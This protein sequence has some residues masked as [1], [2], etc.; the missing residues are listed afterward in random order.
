MAAHKLES[1]PSM[2]RE[3][4]FDDLKEGVRRELKELIMQPN[5]VDAIFVANNNLA[6]RVLECLNEMELRIPQ[7]IA[8][9]VFDDIEMFK[10]CHPPITAVAQPIENIGYAALDTLLTKIDSK[11]KDADSITTVLEPT[12]VIRRSCG[13]YLRKI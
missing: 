1:K 13:S 11:D 10:F 9:V 5:S 3:V 6:I 7:D 2:I 12:L 8:M 4:P